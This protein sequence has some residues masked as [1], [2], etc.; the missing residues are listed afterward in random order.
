MSEKQDGTST[1]ASEKDRWVILA[2]GYKDGPAAMSTMANHLRSLG[3]KVK[4]VA[5]SPSNGSAPL[6]ELVDRVDAQLGRLDD[7]RNMDVVGYS[8]GALVMQ[9]WM[10]NRGGH[11]KVRR[12]ISIAG[13]HAGTVWAYF[14]PRPGLM[15]MRPN[16]H[17]L[18]EL[19]GGRGKL[20]DVDCTCIWTPYDVT[21]FPARSCVF[22]DSEV[23]EIP[24]KLHRWLVRDPRVLRIVGDTLT[25]SA[26]GSL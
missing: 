13:P 21:V 20:K 16:S 5:L 7:A 2:H 3:R 17:F 12:F 8:M 25:A 18:Q 24:V 15:D 26:A 10:Q 19:R 23:H 11:E 9:A 22:D 4:S 1:A 14:V 6:G